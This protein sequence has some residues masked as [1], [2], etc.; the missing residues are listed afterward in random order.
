MTALEARFT[1]SVSREPELLT[2]PESLSGGDVD[3]VVRL[4]E[5]AADGFFVRNVERVPQA[6]F[7]SEETAPAVAGGA[8]SV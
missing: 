6:G 4:D 5:V 8:P 1:S 7:A 3:S 2:P